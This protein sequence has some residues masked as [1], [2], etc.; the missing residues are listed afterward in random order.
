MEEV[1]KRVV[2]DNI[3][4]NHE[5]SNLGRVRH[6][7]TQYILTPTTTPKG[8]LSVH[9]VIGRKHSRTF[10]VHRLVAIMFIPNPDNLSQVN[11][12][13]ENKKNNNVNNLEWCDTK[14][15]NNYGTRTER[16]SL[17]R[18]KQVRCVETGEI[19]ESVQQVSEF[20]NVTDCMVSMCCNG[21]RKSCKGLHFEF[22]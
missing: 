21:K 20:L 2:V 16:S 17:N 8:Y 11:H 4:Y 14:Y 7:R 22:V 12:I 6:I 18:H 10:R 1:W 5:V 9:L 15:N 3:V 19:F 13:D